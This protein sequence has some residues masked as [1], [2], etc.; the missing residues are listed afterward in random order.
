MTKPL[1]PDL[2]VFEKKCSCGRTH[3]NNTATGVRYHFDADEIT[4]SGWFWECDCKSTLF[5]P[6]FPEFMEAA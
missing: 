1:T 2:P 6:A 4:M 5:L 3:T